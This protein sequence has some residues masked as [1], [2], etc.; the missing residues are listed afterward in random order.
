MARV[1]ARKTKRKRL[2]LDV[3]ISTMKRIDRLRKATEAESI[4]EV[5]R[6]ALA[7]YDLIIE[8]RK[9]GAKVYIQ[10]PDGPPIEIEI[11]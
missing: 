2:N 10:A 8:R 5:I 1:S 4:T 3:A 7:V 11:L 9:E 6:K